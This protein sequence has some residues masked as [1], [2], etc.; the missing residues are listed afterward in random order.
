MRVF[1]KRIQRQREV[2]VLDERGKKVTRVEEY[3]S[4]CLCV[5]HSELGVVARLRTTVDDV[6]L[7]R[8]VP[9]RKGQ[10]YFKEPTAHTDVELS[11][12]DTIP[13]AEV[14]DVGELDGGVIFYTARI[15]GAVAARGMLRFPEDV[16]G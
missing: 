12:L 9:T 6:R 11:H 13:V 3:Q 15:D 5:Q 2:T 1:L 7:C 8:F 16:E 4:P 10:R 14:A